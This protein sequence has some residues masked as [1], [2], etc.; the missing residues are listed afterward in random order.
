MYITR[1]HLASPGCPYL[2]VLHTVLEGRIQLYV[3]YIFTQTSR[4][5]LDHKVPTIFRGLFQG[6]SIGC[7]PA[8]FLLNQIHSYQNQEKRAI[9][10]MCLAPHVIC[11]Q[12]QLTPLANKYVHN[13]QV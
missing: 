2:Y 5:G 3:V 4:G 8:N 9:A 11:I 6:D 13:N 7:G 12:Y 10:S 1:Q